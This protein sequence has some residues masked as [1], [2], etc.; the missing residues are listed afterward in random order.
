VVFIVKNNYSY[1]QGLKGYSQRQKEK[2]KKKKEKN[3]KV[4][5][6]F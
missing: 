1:H 4:K 2:R 5:S 6:N 3:E